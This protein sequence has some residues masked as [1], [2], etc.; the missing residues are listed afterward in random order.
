MDPRRVPQMAQSG[1]V[2]SATRGLAGVVRAG[3]VPNRRGFDDAVAAGVDEVALF[4]AASE[5]FNR[6]NL[7]CSIEQSIAVFAEI[8]SDAAQRNIPVRGYLSCV[9]GCPYEGAV[10]PGR[11]ADLAARL[12]QI[13]CR[14]VSLADTIGVGV[15]VQVTRLLA[16]VVESCDVNRL[17]VH[18]HDTYGQA[19]AN[20][21]AAIDAGVTVVDSAV[22]GLGGCPFA[23]GSSGNIATEDL[24]YCLE[25]SGLNTGIDL[26]RLVEVGREVCEALDIPYT[27]RAGNAL[28]ARRWRN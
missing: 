18:M 16:R 13:G 26:E 25:S 11:V 1:A 17:A 10:D 6:R 27:S 15:A 9:A 22:A 21:L 14:E 28:W 19:L 20:I 5:T 4:T 8:C 23:P 24:V 7:N 12:L 3:L 2:F